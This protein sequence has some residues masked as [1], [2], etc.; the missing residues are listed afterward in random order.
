M[1]NNNMENNDIENKENEVIISKNNKGMGLSISSLVIG[2]I[3]LIPAIFSAILSIDSL[4]LA[5][6][7]NDIGSGIGSVL[8]VLLLIPTS[9][10]TFIV[11]AISLGLGIGGLAKAMNKTVKNLG[12]SGT[13]I[14]A[15]SFVLSL[16]SFVIRVSIQ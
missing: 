7:E 6:T 2:V 13:V 5:S 9:I 16:L 11:S 8:L 1:E 14:S 10:A 3:C 15:V 4:I 12:I